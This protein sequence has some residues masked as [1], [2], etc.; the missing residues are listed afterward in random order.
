M[1]SVH[2]CFS[3]SS[4]DLLATRISSMYN[5]AQNTMADLIHKA[6]KCLGHNAKSVGHPHIFKKKSKRCNDSCFRNVIGVDWY[7]IKG[8]YEV[9]L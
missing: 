7:L 9:T 3:C 8:P 6:P 4:G 1:K 2:R 5:D